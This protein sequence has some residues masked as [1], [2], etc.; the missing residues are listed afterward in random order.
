[1]IINIAFSRI[2]KAR[3]GSKSINRWMSSN[4]AFYTIDAYI[5]FFH[6]TCL[7]LLWSMRLRWCNESIIFNKLNGNTAT[8]WL[9]HSKDSSLSSVSILLQNLFYFMN[10]S[11]MKQPRF[12]YINNALLNLLKP[13]LHYKHWLFLLSNV[14]TAVVYIFFFRISDMRFFRRYHSVIDLART[15]P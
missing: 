2:Y 9:N 10:Y 1:M 13:D 5:S 4:C 14:A 7:V 15:Q 11:A 6:T 3:F 12:G 8:I